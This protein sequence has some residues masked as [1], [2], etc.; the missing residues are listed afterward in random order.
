LKVI[1][2]IIIIIITTDFIRNTKTELFD[3]KLKD[4]LEI[5]NLER[6]KDNDT[7]TQYNQLNTNTLY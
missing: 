3:E 2:A 1:T 6:I 7:K 4:T 5:L